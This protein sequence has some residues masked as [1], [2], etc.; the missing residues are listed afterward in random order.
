MTLVDRLT[1]AL[2]DGRQDE[3]PHLPV[4]LDDVVAIIGNERR[5]WILDDLADHSETTLRA[6][7]D[8]RCVDEYGAGYTGQERRREWVAIYQNHLPTLADAD[9]IDYD[10]VSGENDVSRGPNYEGYV[11]AKDALEEICETPNQ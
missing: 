6:M 11:A 3:D 4:A 10:P 9:V 7:V 2:D 8:R 1:S 5:R